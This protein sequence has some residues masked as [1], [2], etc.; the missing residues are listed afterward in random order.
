MRVLSRILGSGWE[1]ANDSDS[2]G[3]GGLGR[4]RKHWSPKSQF[5]RRFKRRQ[6]PRATR[7][8]PDR[9]QTD[10]LDVERISWE[11]SPPGSSSHYRHIPLVLLSVV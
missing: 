6:S 7:T 11:A 3:S 2:G 10:G 1:R 5:K 9:G 8:D 4:L